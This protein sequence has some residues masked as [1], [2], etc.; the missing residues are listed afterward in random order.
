MNLS[1]EMAAGLGENTLGVPSFLSARHSVE[2]YSEFDDAWEDGTDDDLVDLTPFTPDHALSATSRCRSASNLVDIWDFLDPKEEEEQLQVQERVGSEALHMSWSPSLHQLF[3]SQ[4]VPTPM[5]CT[6][7]VRDRRAGSRF[8]LNEVN[9]ALFEQPCTPI[10][11]SGGTAF[12]FR[13]AYKPGCEPP[14][15]N[16]C[17]L[18]GKDLSHAMDELDFYGK[19]KVVTDNDVQWQAFGS[20][21]IGCHGISRLSCVTDLETETTQTRTLLLLENLRN[22]FDSMRLCDVKMGSETSVTGWKG[23]TRL[24]A[25]KNHQLDSRTNSM[26]EGVRL[27]GMELPPRTLEERIKAVVDSHTTM[28][29]VR[30]GLVGSKAAKRFTLQRLHAHEFLAGLLDVS[31]FGAGA[32]MHT[33]SAA[34]SALTAVGRLLVALKGLPAPQMWIGSSLAIALEVGCLCK[35]PRVLVKVFDWGRAELTTQDEHRALPALERSQRMYYWRQYFC[36]LCRVYWELSRIVYHRCCCPSWTALVFEL[37]SEQLSV[38]RAA[39]VPGKCNDEVLGMAVYPM[40]MLQETGTFANFTLPLLRQRCA[41]PPSFGA[42]HVRLSV[43][44]GVQC[45]EGSTI[46]QLQGA[47]KLLSDLVRSGTTVTVIRV[48]AF[49]V[50]DD[51]MAHF[52]AWSDSWPEPVPSGRVCAQKTGPG[53]TVGATVVWDATLEVVGLGKAASKEAQS[54]LVSE[55]NLA[56]KTTGPASDW[57]SEE[58]TDC[59]TGSAEIVSTPWESL[60]PSVLAS[61]PES[62]EPFVCEF[63]RHLVPWLDLEDACPSDWGIIPQIQSELFARPQRRRPFRHVPRAFT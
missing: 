4:S 53:T 63:S 37:R 55:L 36:A 34:W 8:L 6:G 22:G 5:S 2:S 58:S 16:R 54:R 60:L 29:R 41:D 26:A 45:G 42:L 43:S 31:T 40:T 44:E 3:G 35:S 38:L 52:S 33:H 32:E 10:N 50:A 28:S 62:E 18:I 59:D 27:E 46:L 13:I 11:M 17:H 15:V 47:T 21:A 49:E 9:P 24:H 20:M 39:I 57:E 14:G 19:L 48:I 25:W 30:A 12:F 51:A 56:A 23:K 1:P 61:T 7:E